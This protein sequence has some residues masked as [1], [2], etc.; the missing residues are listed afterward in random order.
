MRKNVFMKDLISK[1]A[2]EEIRSL[3]N[4]IAQLNKE[5]RESR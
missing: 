5:V 1:M 4:E 3:A 2:D